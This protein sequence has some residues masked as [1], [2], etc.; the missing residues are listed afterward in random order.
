VV[1]GVVVGSV[2]AGASVPVL[3]A[4]VGATVLVGSAV[5]GATVLVGSAVVGASVLV[6]S[7][8]VGATEHK[9]RNTDALR[10]MAATF[11]GDRCFI[12]D[13]KLLGLWRASTG[14]QPDYGGK[15]IDAAKPKIVGPQKV[16]LN[17]Q[18]RWWHIIVF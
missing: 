18:W 16:C 15:D 2:V 13:R 17:N 14:I 6:G 9:I 5:V 12:I 3:A 11:M 10:T 1:V 4:V 7:A 8:V